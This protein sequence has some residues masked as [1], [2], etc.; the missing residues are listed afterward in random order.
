M[1]AVMQESSVKM[2]YK[3]E[4]KITNWTQ[5]NYYPV[6]NVQRNYDENSLNISVEDFNA[7]IWILNEYI[8]MN[9]VTQTRLKNILIVVWLV[10]HISYHSQIITDLKNENDSLLVKL[11]SGKYLSKNLLDF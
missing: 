3:L 2:K 6:I 8:E 5:L 9:I 1:Q 7:D 10:P 11:Q 4:D